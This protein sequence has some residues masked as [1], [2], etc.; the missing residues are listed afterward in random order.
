MDI[1]YRRPSE[2]ILYRACL[3]GWS[4]LGGNVV[5]GNPYFLCLS[6]KGRN[7]RSLPLHLTNRRRGG[8]ICARSSDTPC[9][10][11]YFP[12]V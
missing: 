3:A 6:L 9:F 4:W 5:F 11:Q 12:H 10:V 1:R 8:Q 2:E 7:I